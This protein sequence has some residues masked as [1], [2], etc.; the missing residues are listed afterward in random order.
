MNLY[1][2][3]KL[4][5]LKNINVKPHLAIITGSGIKLFKS[6]QPLFVINYTD[7]PALNL[8]SHLSTQN[9]KGHEGKLRLYKIKNKYVLVFSGRHHLYEG[10]DIDKVVANVRIAYDL[11]IKNLL[12]TNAAGGLNKNYKA[13]DLM[14]ITGFINMMQETE[15]GVIDSITQLPKQVSSDLSNLI[16]K[17]NKN[18][19]KYGI[20]AGML[21]PSYETYSEINLLKQLGAD[22]V[23]MSTI[24]EMICAKSLKL[25]YAGISTISN[26]WNKS[27]NPSH[28][29]VLRNVKKA[30]KK[31][32]DLIVKLLKA[33]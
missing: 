14:L 28:E 4:F 26:V 23:G 2:K 25:N 21:G 3:T 20:Y 33:L 32:N 5:L 8:K 30:N 11:G 12:I 19:I 24:P 15:R 31:L 22:S 17:Q 6:E 27:H 29:E 7:L 13:G 1:K 16:K 9:V 18:Q 10:L